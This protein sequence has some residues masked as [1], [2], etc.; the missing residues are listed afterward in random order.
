METK[1]A[2]YT[3]EFWVQIVLQVILTLNTLNIWNYVPN[4][5]EWASVLAQAILGSF[6]MLSRGIAKNK[7][8]IDPDNPGNYTLLPTKKKMKN[9]R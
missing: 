3:T 1:P 9:A 7:G 4:R 6:Y 8:S 5:F 2:I